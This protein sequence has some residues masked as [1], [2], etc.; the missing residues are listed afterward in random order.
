MMTNSAE[1][2]CDI[3]AGLNFTTTCTASLWVS[4]MI[5][6]RVMAARKAAA[7]ENTKA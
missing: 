5:I 4:G 7:K 6:Y 2:L 3:I 1:T